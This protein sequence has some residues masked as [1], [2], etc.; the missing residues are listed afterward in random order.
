M[1]VGIMRAGAAGAD[2]TLFDNGAFAFN[3]GMGFGS[4][5][6]VDDFVLAENGSLT[7]ASFPYYNTSNPGFGPVLEWYVYTDA[8]GSPGLEFASGA[9]T[10]LASEVLGRY[11]NWAVFDITFELDEPVSLEGGVVYWFGLQ[12]TGG[13]L[14]VAR[15]WGASDTLPGG[16]THYENTLEGGWISVPVEM[17]FQLLPEPSNALLGSSALLLLGALAVQQKRRA[18]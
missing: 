18:P 10:V 4:K 16:N 11:G 6:V 14:V 1:A 9:G 13:T 8:A 5:I 12:N 3:G 15:H 7:R 2:T 17:S